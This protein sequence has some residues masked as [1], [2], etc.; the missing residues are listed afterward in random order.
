MLPS[1]EGI[2]LGE[3]LYNRLGCKCVLECTENSP[4]SADKIFTEMR[5]IEFLVH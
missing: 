4:P 1:G 2:H 3:V 5:I